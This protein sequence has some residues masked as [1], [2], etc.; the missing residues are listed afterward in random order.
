MA[1]SLL[2]RMLSMNGPRRTKNLPLENRKQPIF[3]TFVAV[4]CFFND[5]ISAAEATAGAK[6]D[7]DEQYRHN[8]TP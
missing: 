5:R 2:E 7:M 3:H 6:R 8:K 4:H 1:L